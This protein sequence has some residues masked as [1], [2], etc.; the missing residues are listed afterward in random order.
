MDRLGQTPEALA[1]GIVRG[2]LAL[3]VSRF[4]AEQAQSLAD[5]LGTPLLAT[6][7]QVVHGSDGRIRSDLH[8]TQFWP[9]D[10][11]AVWTARATDLGD[12]VALARGRFPSDVPALLED[13]HANL[14]SADRHLAALAGEDLDALL[15]RQGALRDRADALS[16]VPAGEVPARFALDSVAAAADLRTQLRTLRDAALSEL[17]EYERGHGVPAG[18]TRL[19][20]SFRASTV[21]PPHGQRAA[22][23]G[24]PRSR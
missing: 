19:I 12:A 13:F 10:P 21:E 2:R 11:T 1:A 9:G 3:A 24:I 22:A 14:A 17:F 16:A 8:W 15:T 5:V 20:P 18:G 6:A 7:G 23:V 4:P